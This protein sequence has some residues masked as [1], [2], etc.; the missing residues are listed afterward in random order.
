MPARSTTVKSVPESRV[1]RPTPPVVVSIAGS[2]SSGGAGIQADIATLAGIGVLCATAITAVTAQ[3]TIGIQKIQVLPRSMVEAQLHSVISDMSFEA[4]KTGMLSTSETIKAIASFAARG[5]LPNLVVDPVLIASDH[6]DLVVDRAYSAYWELLPFAAVITPNA[7]EAALLLSE[8]GSRQEKMSCEDNVE[9]SARLL[10]ERCG[11]ATVVITGGEARETDICTDVVCDADGLEQL[12]A[13]RVHT[14]NT[15]GTGCTFSAAI[16]GF[17]A[18]G[19]ERREAIEC[20]KQ[21]VTDALLGAA[22]WRL[23]SPSGHGPLD[24]L[25]QQDDS[26]ASR[27]SVPNHPCPRPASQPVHTQA[28]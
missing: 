16:A 14:T 20:A 13:P 12:C 27:S 5:Q 22:C 23:G 7:V 21:Y 3:N 9:R 2:D 4:T 15:H 11:G 17:L 26:N 1:S 25:R 6:S 19:L 28:T 10:Y 8:S 18:K 24:H